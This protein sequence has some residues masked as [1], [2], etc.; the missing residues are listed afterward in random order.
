MSAYKELCAEVDDA[1]KRM[2]C[3][4]CKQP[5][6]R[7]CQYPGNHGFTLGVIKYNGNW[8]RSTATCNSNECIRKAFSDKRFC[9]PYA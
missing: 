7:A 1:N 8:E 3:F 4:Y 2:V 5:R 6:D 9:L